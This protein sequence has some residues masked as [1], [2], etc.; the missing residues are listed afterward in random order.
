MNIMYYIQ[1]AHSFWDWIYFVA[2]IVVSL[3]DLTF[4]FFHTYDKIKELS[5]MH[6]AVL[7]VDS[8]MYAAL[9]SSSYIIS[10]Q[11]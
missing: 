6:V 9:P 10:S 4:V 11:M 5:G 1:D 2:L 7:S 3:S 8:D